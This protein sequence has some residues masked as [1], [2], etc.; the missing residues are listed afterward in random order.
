[1]NLS[2]R[3][4][5]NKV[6]PL[7]S[8]VPQGGVH[9][10]TGLYLLDNSSTKTIEV[11]VICN[12]SFLDKTLNFLEILNKNAVL[13]QSFCSNIHNKNIITPECYADFDWVQ[14]V[15]LR[16]HR[17]T[18]YQVGQVL[19]HML[20][21]D[22]CVKSEN[23]LIVLESGTALQQDFKE[24]LSPG[25]LISLSTDE[26]M[27]INNNYRCLKDVK[28]YSI[29]PVM[30]KKLKFTVLKDGILDSLNLMLRQDIYP[31]VFNKIT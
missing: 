2:I 19:D 7:I 6:I 26:P 22:Y 21:W 13:F 1:M 27:I 5:D 14:E 20:A 9:N 10:T 18:P 28:A 11:A 12:N 3:I 17:L 8:S 23:P 30:A 16:N 15:K 4:P 24:H 31:L 29:H 25:S